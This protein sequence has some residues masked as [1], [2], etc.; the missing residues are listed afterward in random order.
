MFVV[1]QCF[2]ADWLVDRNSIRL[3]KLLIQQFL[4]VR[5]CGFYLCWKYWCDGI[6]DAVEEK[7]VVVG[8]VLVAA[9]A[10]AAVVAGVLEITL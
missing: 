9:A 6:D 3:L 8:V 7:V 10:A 2:H 5:F 1:L 4:K